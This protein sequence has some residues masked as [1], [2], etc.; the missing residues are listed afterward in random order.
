MEELTSPVQKAPVQKE[1]ELERELNRAFQ[2][3]N[4]LASSI[5]ILGERLKPVLSPEKPQEA[6][7]KDETAPNTEISKAIRDIS[8][9]INTQRKKIQDL[10]DRLGV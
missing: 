8:Y 4:E 7:E 3:I 1:S 5:D 6:G 9:K 2:E 10:I